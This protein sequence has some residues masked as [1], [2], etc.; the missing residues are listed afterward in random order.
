MDRDTTASDTL[1]SLKA[2]SEIFTEQKCSEYHCWGN[3]KGNG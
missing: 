2:V 3:G 1:C